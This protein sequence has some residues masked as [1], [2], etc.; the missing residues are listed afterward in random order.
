[1]NRHQ[2]NCNLMQDHM[3]S[4]KLHYHRKDILISSMAHTDLRINLRNIAFLHHML[5]NFIDFNNLNMRLDYI[6]SIFDHINSKTYSIQDHNKNI[7][8]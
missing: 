6:F 3:L 4:K 7:N 8:S 2:A 1:M 5:Y